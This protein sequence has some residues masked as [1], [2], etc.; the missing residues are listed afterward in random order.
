MQ[1]C[2]IHICS[3]SCKAGLNMCCR[4]T[5]SRRGSK[6]LSVRSLV[7]RMSRMQVMM[8]YSPFFCSFRGSCPSYS[9]CTMQ[10]FSH[11]AGTARCLLPD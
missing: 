8:V 7:L 5:V 10:G 4:L 1:S 11:Q 2:T 3:S 6:Q 9:G